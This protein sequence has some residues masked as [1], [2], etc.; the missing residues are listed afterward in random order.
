MGFIGKALTE[1]LETLIRGI[2]HQR[3]Y[4]ESLVKSERVKMAVRKDKKG[5]TI[6]YKGNKWGRKRLPKQTINR[7]LELHKLGYPIRSIQKNVNVYDKNR[8]PKP[9]SVGAVHKIITEYSK[10]KP[11]NNEV[12]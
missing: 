6:S 12:S 9:I 1:F 10:E 8:N 5:R 4:T 7:V 2:E 11:R 3:A